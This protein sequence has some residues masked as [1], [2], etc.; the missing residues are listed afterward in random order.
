MLNLSKS[1]EHEVN[2]WLENTCI[3]GQENE[4]HFPQGATT[5]SLHAQQTK[6]KGR[7][8]QSNFTLQVSPLSKLS[9]LKV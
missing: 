9:I 7:P 3:W 4:M 1:I 8:L 6:K 2:K 5:Y